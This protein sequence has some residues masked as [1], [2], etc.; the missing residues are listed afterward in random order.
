MTW[1]AD[2]MALSTGEALALAAICFVAGV[3]RGFSGFALSAMI[4][5]SAVLILPPIYLIPI[6]FLLETT[7]SVLMFRGGSREGDW[8]MVWR[9]T[10]G[11]VI[12]TPVGLY[13]TTTLPV[14]QSRMLAL[15]VVL[16]LA[17]LQLAKL[18]IPGLGSPIGTYIAGGVSGIAS[19]LA[20]VGGMVVA[21][22]V[23]S[24]NAPAARMR[25]T[26]VLYLAV[27]LVVSCI[28]LI[29]FEVLTVQSAV[30]AAFLAPPVILGVLIGARGFT[31]KY[32]HL[33]R[34]F[35]LC[36]LVGL[37]ALGLARMA[38]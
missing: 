10:A 9:L 38:I 7:A 19:G 23:L 14:D 35:C 30:R 34:P 1:I 24:L 6:C 29:W 18:R 27:T 37:A 4:M 21:L 32:Q 17:A 13:L 33:Y 11:V 16:V 26:L 36:L 15:L 5:A 25:A 28:W 22:F 8:P 31:P 12:G 3:V 20:S 2:M